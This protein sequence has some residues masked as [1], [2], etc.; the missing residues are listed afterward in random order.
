MKKRWVVR[1]TALL[2]GSG[3]LA[4]AAMIADVGAASALPHRAADDTIYVSPLGARHNIGRSCQ[5]A[6]YST[7]QSGLRHAASDD[8]VVVCAGTYHEGVLLNKP[9]HLKG[10]DAVIDA[11]GQ[12]VGVTIA[13]SD[14]KVD[15]F[16]VE[17]ATGEGILAVGVSEVVI[18]SN[19]VDN[20]NMGGPTSTHREC[21]ATG[22]VPGDCG[23]GIHLMGV[24]DSRVSANRVTDNQ[25]GILLTDEAGATF[26]NVITENT[27]QNN[28]VDG[29]ITL[30]SHRP[31]SSEG[32]R[33]SGV[34]DNSIRKNSVL[35]NG[36]TGTRGGGVL[37]ATPAPGTAVYDNDVAGNLIAENGLAGVTLHA[38]GRHQDLNGNTIHDNFIGPN[39]LAGDPPPPVGAG[40]PNLTGVL[41]YST[42]VRVNVNISNN[43]IAF[44]T[45]GIWLSPTVDAEGLATNHYLAV[46][47][48]VFVS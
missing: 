30:A 34:F 11:T 4:A 13:E 46:T 17:N 19:V 1:F 26:D 42:V 8:T 24:S 23:E 16:T 33:S 10:L 14:T 47:T 3:L 40:D 21:R 28:L 15:G 5:T 32:R 25:G 45:Y 48:P 44:D 2:A 20:N 41:V 18:D 43:I 31:T 12:N 38:H 37:L 7:I 39:N 36:L 9:V 27:V 35:H 29:G 6:R 22:S